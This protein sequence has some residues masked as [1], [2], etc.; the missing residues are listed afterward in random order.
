MDFWDL[1][2]VNNIFRSRYS[3][4]GCGDFRRILSD[5][6]RNRLVS[7][8]YGADN[9]IGDFDIV[10]FASDVETCR[11]PGDAVVFNRII[12]KCIP[13]TAVLFILVPEQDTMGAVFVDNVI[14]KY[15]VGILMTY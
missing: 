12:Y 13:V 10:S 15:I 1:F 2:P 7:F 4:S 14:L 9:I 5:K 3:V 8:P 6:N 11:F